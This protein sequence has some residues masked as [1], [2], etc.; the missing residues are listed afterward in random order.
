MTYLWLSLDLNLREKPSHR[1]VLTV[2]R[3]FILKHT[4]K[5]KEHQ[6]SPPPALTTEKPDTQATLVALL[7]NRRLTGQTPAEFSSNTKVRTRNLELMMFYDYK[8]NTLAVS[9]RFLNIR[10]SWKMSSQMNS[11]HEFSVNVTI[12]RDPIYKPDYKNYE[13]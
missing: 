11:P 1:K 4:L 13:Q 10:L 8:N 2:V 12:H 5:K 6:L 7:N 3:K 9:L